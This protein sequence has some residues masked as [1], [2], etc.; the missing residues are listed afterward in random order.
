MT[1][2]TV[3]MCT[4]MVTRI[5]EFDEK[6]LEAIGNILAG[7]TPLR[8]DCGGLVVAFLTPLPPLPFLREL[9]VCTRGL[10]YWL[11]ERG[12]WLCRYCLSADV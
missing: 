5:K 6:E 7:T 9:E 12:E 2:H 8:K 11:N 3:D 1:S 4:H 10:R